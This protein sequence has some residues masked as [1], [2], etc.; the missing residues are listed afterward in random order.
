MPDPSTVR[1]WAAQLFCFWLL[2]TIRLC[3]AAGRSIF[4]P[5]TILAWDWNAVRL[6]LPVEVN[7]S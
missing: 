7:S 2:L 4:D 6:I 1:R 3:Q 5:S